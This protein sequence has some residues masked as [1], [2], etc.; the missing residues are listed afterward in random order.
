MGGFFDHAGEQSPAQSKEGGN[1]G[2]CEKSVHLLSNRLFCLFRRV[3]QN[4]LHK[5]LDLFHAYIQ[6]S[7]LLNF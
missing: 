4:R 3:G 2:C 1:H 6:A 7:C 5:K